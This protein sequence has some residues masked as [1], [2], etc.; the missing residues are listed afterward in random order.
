MKIL[1]LTPPATTE[2]GRFLAET[3]PL[4][5]LYLAGYLEKNGYTDLKVVDTDALRMT[6]QE[7]EELLK[8]EKP[9]LLGITGTSYIMPVVLKT[10]KLARELLP[11]A[12]IVSGG[13]G[14]TIEPEKTLREFPG[15][16]NFVVVGEGETTFLELIQRLEKGEKKFDDIKGLAY[17]E[18]NKLIT[19]PARGFIWDLDSIPWPAYH[20]LQPAFLDYYGMHAQYKEMGRP[21]AV[22]LASRGCPHRCAFCSLKS[23]PYRARDPKKVV[24]EM[25]FYRDKYKI[26]SIQIYD[27]EFIGLNPKQNEWIKELC[28]EIEKEGL[29]KELTFLVQGRCSEYVDLEILEKM[30]EAGFVWIWWGV[31]SGSQKILDLIKKDIKVENV[32]K[33]FKL[34]KKA[35]IKSMMFI[36]VGFPGEI[37]A[38]IK[39]TANIIKKAKPDQVRIHILS[40]YPGSELRD[41][42]E[43]NN[44]LETTDCYKFDSR[45]NVIHHTFEMSAEEIKK[46]YN[47]LVWRFENGYWYFVKFLIKS[48]I[49][50]DGWKQIFKRMEKA[51]RHL[52]G[53]LK[54]SFRK[55]TRI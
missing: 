2:I 5:L 54:I 29:H 33:V 47:L 48:L 49:T 7:V 36:M 38:D 41:Y 12:I 52:S 4:G 25:R 31:E 37:P 20:L 13:F 21:N 34:A 14:P 26:Q 51:M 6:W 46:Y 50:K 17:L 15:T 32:F 19:T 45:T 43:K 11:E 44:L 55:T 16:T 10:A 27:D 8:K 42:L 23:K 22:M 39:L 35:G 3:P 40:P 53:W 9:D 28:E 30:K 1:L 24:Q 18:N